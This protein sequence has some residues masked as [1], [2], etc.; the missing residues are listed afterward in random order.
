[1]SYNRSVKSTVQARLD[2]ATSKILA[3]LVRRTGK[4]PSDVVREGLRLMA[5]THAAPVSPRV[6]GLGQFTS[7]VP[8]LGSSKHH[9]KGFGR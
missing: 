3:Q 7:G 4:K 8:D 2:P 6:L 5:A 1:M 9:L